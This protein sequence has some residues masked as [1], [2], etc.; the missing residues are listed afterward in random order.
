M[1]KIELHPEFLVSNGERQF[2]V[3]TYKEYL[4]LQE[5]IEDTED[6]YALKAAREENK[7]EPLFTIEETK[8]ELGLD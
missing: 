8:K 1:T 5:W 2:A 7:N 3:L 6:L 4:A